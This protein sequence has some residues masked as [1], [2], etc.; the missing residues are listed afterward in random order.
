MVPRFRVEL[1]TDQRAELLHAR[2]RHPKAHVR[3]KVTAILK[4]ADGQHI[5]EVA[6][7]G[8]HRRHD[9]ST[10]STWVRRYLAEGLPGLLV[11]AGRGR[12]AAFSPSVRGG[13]RRVRGHP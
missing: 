8:L 1:S 11:R 5:E 10:L 12:R 9:E 3:E 2:D 6:T 13:V 7:N 4:L